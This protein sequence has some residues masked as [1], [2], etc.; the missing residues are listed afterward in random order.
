MSQKLIC[1]IL[2]IVKADER[3]LLS[4]CHR[5]L[6]YHNQFHNLRKLAR[7]YLVEINYAIHLQDEYN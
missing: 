6:L 1:D 7:L 2:R 4:H 5:S 3:S